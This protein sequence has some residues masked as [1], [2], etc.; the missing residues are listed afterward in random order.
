M[1][2]YIS[3]VPIGSAEE[4]EG[5]TF[6]ITVARG[7]LRVAYIWMYVCKYNWQLSEIRFNLAVAKSHQQ[8][9]MLWDW[10]LFEVVATDKSAEIR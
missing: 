6:S 9:K 5:I 1:K 2:V 3:V 10:S 8:P 4:M 7:Q